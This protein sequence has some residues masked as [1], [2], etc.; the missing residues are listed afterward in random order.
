MLKRRLNKKGR[1]LIILLISII[2]YVINCKLSNYTQ[3][4]NIILIVNIINWLYLL[5]ILPILLIINENV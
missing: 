4:N 3:V 2:I 1:L 5:L